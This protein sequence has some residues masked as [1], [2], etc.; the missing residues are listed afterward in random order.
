[1]TK[2]GKTRTSKFCEPSA[3]ASVLAHEKGFLKKVFHLAKKVLLFCQPDD[4][5]VFQVLA[6][7]IWTYFL[8]FKVYH[9]H[10]IHI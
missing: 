4:K 8:V 9:I 3:P 1:M 7:T 2:N 5:C 10:L 6:R